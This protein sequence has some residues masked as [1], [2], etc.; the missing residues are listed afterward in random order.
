M[1]LNSNF[2]K[3]LCCRKSNIESLK[4]EA[5]FNLLLSFNS[6]FGLSGCWRACM[7]CVIYIKHCHSWFCVRYII[8]VSWA[9]FSTRGVSVWNMS[10]T[11]PGSVWAQGE[12][13]SALIFM[14]EEEQMS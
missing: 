14:A 13:P 2:S 8:Q 5:A 1:I 6:C 7:C 3:A 10:V 4:K 12:T 11:N 9:F